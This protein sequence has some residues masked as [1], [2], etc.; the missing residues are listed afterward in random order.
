MR[1]SGAIQNPIRFLVDKEEKATK[2][3]AKLG[4]FSYQP[5]S[6]AGAKNKKEKTT[7]N[8]SKARK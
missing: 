5:K 1:E 4:R 7:K 8:R 3:E 2:K 6:V